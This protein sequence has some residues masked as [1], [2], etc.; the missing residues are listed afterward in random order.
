MSELDIQRRKE[1]KHNRKKWMIIQLVAIILFAAI[2]IGSFLVY[3]QMNRTYYVE[4]TERG[5]VDYMVQYKEN[6]FFDDEWIAA[7]QTYISSLVKGMT[8]SFDYRLYTESSDLGFKYGYKIDAKLLVASKDSGTPYYTYEE[9]IFPPKET[10][11]NSSSKVNIDETVWI[12][13]TKYN[14]M[15]QTFIDTYNLK[16]SASCTLIITM[17]VDILSTNTQ[18]KKDNQNSYTTS[19]N[20]PLA[21][22]S[23]NIFTTSSSPDNEVKVMEYQDIADR[24]I[25]FVTSVSAVSLDALLVIALLIFLHLTKNEDITYAAK[26]RKILRSYSS[27][28]QRI[29]GEFEYEGYQIVMIKT[30]NEMLG[31]RDTMQLPI[32]MSENHD[33]TMTRFV[34]PTHTKILY[35]F[36]IKVDNYDDIYGEPEMVLLEEV[37]EE[38]L[39][40]AMAQPDIALEEI[41]FVADDDEEEEEG[42]EVIGVVW[43]ERAHRNKVYRYDPNGESLEN[44]DVVLVPSRDVARN[45][46]I[47]RKA[48]VAH[49]N[50][51]VDPEVLKH[52][53]KKII[54]VVKRNVSYS[55]T[56]NANKTAEAEENQLQTK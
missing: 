36:E 6:Q 18:F 47:L 2:A 54:G 4:Y 11:V 14:Q 8:A 25:F 16:D 56:P 24:D 49:G 28:I 32:L 27:F 1:Y 48:A 52:P 9:N 29:D 35:V 38:V 39:S 41:D 40:E 45:K 12:D 21:V 53:L 15:A 17:N 7:N 26:I 51:K 50:H 20:I 10:S 30:L 13:F 43:P 33:E 42:V 23:F 46:D 34:I 19:M 44:G 55:L 31:I 37:D 22:E 5:T 3:N